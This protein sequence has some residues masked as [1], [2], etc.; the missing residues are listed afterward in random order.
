MKENRHTLIYI[1][2]KFWNIR[3]ERSK[4][5]PKLKNYPASYKGPGE[6]GIRLLNNTETRSN[7]FETLLRVYDFHPR[8]LYSAMLTNQM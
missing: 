4:K 6:N 2:V 3:E 8:I 5:I 1:I 7:A